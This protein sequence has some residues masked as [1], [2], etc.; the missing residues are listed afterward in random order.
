MPARPA[1]DREGTSNMNHTTRNEARAAKAEVLA[2]FGD[3]PSVVGVGITRISEGYGVKLNLEV[4]A[5][6]D[7]NLPK[8]VRRR[9]RLGR[10]RWSHPETLNFAG[11]TPMPPR[12]IR[13]V[14]LAP[15]VQHMHAI[16]DGNV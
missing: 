16:G 13:R 3:D 12:R 10:N 5:A 7:A 11:V 2:A 9:P 1:P 6:P 8:D 4:P 14:R 15:L